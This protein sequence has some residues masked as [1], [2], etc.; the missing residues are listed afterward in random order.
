MKA[1]TDQLVSLQTIADG[2]LADLGESAHRKEQMLKWAL[3]YFR[4][5]KMDIARDV[6]E[7]YLDM[8][9]WKSIILPK[10]CVDWLQLGIRNGEVTNTMV[11][12]NFLATRDCA[13][14]DDAPTQPRYCADD[15]AGEGI[16]F[17]SIDEQGADAG[18][19]YGLMMKD[20]GV[21][22][23]T[24]NR[25]M[26]VN[27]IQLNARIPAG[28]RIY[29]MYLSTL[30]DPSVE[31]VVHPYCQDLIAKGIHYENLKFKRNAGNRNIGL[32]DI[33][34]AKN[35][36]DEELCLVAERRSDLTVDSMMEII[37]SGHRLSPKM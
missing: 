31:S 23:F 8:T 16:Q 6:R 7:T 3:D 15:D 1:H 29:F 2:V 22:Y 28:T 26:R 4:R 14:D 19:M 27:E 9:A 21:G 30:F 32:S 17:N 36:L 20:N 11:N 10:D 12:T 24:P 25:N 13:C 33:A 37:R 18:K 34:M 5:Y 35:E